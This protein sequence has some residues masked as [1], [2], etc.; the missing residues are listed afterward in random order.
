MWQCSIAHDIDHSN[1]DLIIGP[2]GKVVAVVTEKR[3]AV[4]NSKFS[5]AIFSMN[6]AKCEVCTVHCQV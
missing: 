1:S 2:I 3:T 5:N 4:I 6:C